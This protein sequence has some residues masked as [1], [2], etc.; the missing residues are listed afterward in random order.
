MKQG[1]SAFYHPVSAEGTS[2]YGDLGAYL[3]DSFKFGISK[4]TLIQQHNISEVTGS[5]PVEALIRKKMAPPVAF[6]VDVGAKFTVF[7]WESDGK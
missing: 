4:I 7:V 6:W 2:F 5:N 1:A 3:R